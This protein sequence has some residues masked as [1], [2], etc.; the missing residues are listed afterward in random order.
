MGQHAK[1]RTLVNIPK[2]ARTLSDR[3]MTQSVDKL[4][5]FLRGARVTGNFTLHIMSGKREASFSLELSNGRCLVS[6]KPVAK[7][8]FE[9]RMSRDTWKDLA[10]SGISPVDAFLTGKMEVHGNLQFGKRLYALMATKSGIK[11]FPLS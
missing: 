9:I 5:R 10:T 1:L 6:K 2:G 11:D 4:S 8:D 7:S 3:N